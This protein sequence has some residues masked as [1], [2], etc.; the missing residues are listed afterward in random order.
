MAAQ[1]PTKQQIA[2]AKARA[3]GNNPI[4]VTNSGLKKLGSAALIA[5]SF[6]PAG[7]AVKLGRTVA[8]IAGKG[9]KN[10][11]KVYKPTGPTKEQQWEARHEIRNQQEKISEKQ[12]KEHYRS[13][14]K[15]WND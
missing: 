11:G 3:G 1:K 10:V 7:R 8:G 14:S 6:T 5:A 9:G 2:Q 12:L 13:M 4:K 15:Q